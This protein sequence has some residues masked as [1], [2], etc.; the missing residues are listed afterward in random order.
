MPRTV[1]LGPRR[2]MHRRQPP[3]KAAPPADAIGAAKAAGLRYVNDGDAGIRRSKAGANFAYTDPQGRRVKDK[4]TLGR[5][6]RL[7]IPPAWTEVWI[8]LRDDGHIQATGRD[9]R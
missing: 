1:E 3:P 4:A 2:L 7:A 9:A 5:I 8:C 6:R